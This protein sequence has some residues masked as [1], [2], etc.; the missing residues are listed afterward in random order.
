[1]FTATAS[2][3]YALPAQKLWELWTDPEHLAAW[4]RPS[5]EFGPT[6]ASTD[7]REG[8]AYRIEMFDPSGEVHAAYG[9]YVEV[10]EPTKLA[11]T[12]SWEGTEGESLVEVTFTENDG[13]TEVAINH[14]KLDS[15]ESAEEHTHG[16]V[17]CLGVLDELY[18]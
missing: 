10:D 18:A 17:G 14:T 9:V 15:A 3:T 4:H 11:F 12:W 7:V 6:V 8:G 13:A 2:R 1:M 5:L 16:W